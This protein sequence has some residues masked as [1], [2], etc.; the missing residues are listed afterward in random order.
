MEPGL[1]EAMA[2][3]AWPAAES[4]EQGGWLLRRTPQVGR[5]RSNSALPL[6]G[7]GTGPAAIAAVEAHYRDRGA[8]PLVQVAPLEER[9]DLDAALAE[10]G[11]AAGGATDVLV[12]P[13]AVVAA[14]HP[15]VEV[16]DGLPEGWLEDWARAEGRGD[17]LA[18][19][20]ILDAIPA[21]AG[22]A[23]AVHGGQVAGTGLCAV[24]GA[25]AGVFCLATAAGAR[26][27]GV[28]RA[29]LAGLAAWAAERSASRLYLQVEAGN[30]A[31]RAL[32]AGAG[33]TRSHGYHYRSAP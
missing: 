11:W 31:A 22:F 3:R 27:R 24:E 1:I 20:G 25:W 9:A 6:A 19:R 32:F 17:A 28:G 33:F 4:V 12:A 23:R 2:A 10:R 8:R 18:H 16:A 5:R 14:E 7:A 15:G 30:A 13:V 26:R 21:P 29:V